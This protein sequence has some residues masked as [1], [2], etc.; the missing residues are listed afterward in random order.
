MIRL[1]MAKTPKVGAA[2]SDDPE[3][4]ARIVRNVHSTAEAHTA[5]ARRRLSA[6]KNENIFT[7]ASPP[8]ITIQTELGKIDPYMPPVT[9]NVAYQTP[10]EAVW[11]NRTPSL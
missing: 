10:R 4:T 1:K 9:P 3:I 5:P 2:G 6:R 8:K 7:I 11:A